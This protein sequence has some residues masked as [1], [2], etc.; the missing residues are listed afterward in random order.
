MWGYHIFG[1]P[2]YDTTFLTGLIIEIIK[3]FSS[4]KQ[5]EELK[6]DITKTFETQSIITK[7]FDCVSII[8]NTYG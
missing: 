2:I 7:S 6:S 1:G 5:R 3:C 8:G 4:I